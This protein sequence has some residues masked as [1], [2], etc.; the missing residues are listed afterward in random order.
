M[1][2][3]ESRFHKFIMSINSCEAIDDLPEHTFEGKK[4]DYLLFD[5]ELTFEVK[6]LSKD[7]GAELN[8]RFSELAMSDPKFPEFFGKVPVEDII[9]AH[10]EGEKFRLWAL[11]YSGRNLKHLIRNADKQIRDTKSSLALKRSTGVL[12][13][14]N[15]GVPFYNNDFVYNYVSKV[16][17]KKN[18]DDSFERSNVELIW[19]IN[20]VDRSSHQVYANLFIGPALRNK[21]ILNAFDMLESRWA[22]FNAYPV[23]KS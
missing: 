12:I 9:S 11:D 22:S 14:L 8:R 1:N 5:R 16:L 7:R 19:Y 21:G 20:E 4:A 15:E 10:A 2:N 3:L 23:I 13:L 6:H 18:S 17:A